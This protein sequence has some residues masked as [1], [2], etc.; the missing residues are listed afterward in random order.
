MKKRIISAVILLLICS[1]SVFSNELRMRPSTEFFEEKFMTLPGY[2]EA[3]MQKSMPEI[4]QKAYDVGAKD[5]L[6][7]T[8]TDGSA[9]E[10][11]IIE[12]KEDNLNPNGIIEVMKERLSE[13]EAEFAGNEAE[14]V[15]ISDSR[16]VAKGKMVVMAVY[17]SERTAENLIHAVFDH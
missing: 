5:I 16:T 12:M 1:V 10:F 6:V 13:K 4:Y 7:Y 2:R 9:R 17:D 8:A 15:R 14:I 3:N 11:A